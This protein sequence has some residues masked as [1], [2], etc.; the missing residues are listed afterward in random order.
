MNDLAAACPSDHVLFFPAWWI[1]SLGS[2]VL[3]GEYPFKKDIP[4]LTTCPR[5]SW[6][7][8]TIFGCFL[9]EVLS[10]F[11]AQGRSGCIELCPYLLYHR[12]GR[13]TAMFRSRWNEALLGLSELRILRWTG[14]RSLSYRV[15]ESVTWTSSGSRLVLEVAPNSDTLELLSGFVDMYSESNRRL[16]GRPTLL[17]LVKGRQPLTVNRS[18]WL[19]LAGREASCY[20][21]LVTH[22]LWGSS[23]VQAQAYAMGVNQLASSPGLAH[24]DAGKGLAL[25]RRVIRRIYRHGC[26]SPLD[27]L[28]NYFALEEDQSRDGVFVVYANDEDAHA[29]DLQLLR[30]RWLRMQLD[31]LV[32]SRS[33]H[34]PPVDSSV[35]QKANRLIEAFHRSTSP[36][37][38]EAIY[39]QNVLV[40]P[41][42][43]LL[44]EWAL[45]GDTQNLPDT[46]TQN[47]PV[48]ELATLDSRVNDLADNFDS[49]L[50]RLHN[51][52]VDVK[53]AVV[54]HPSL[55]LCYP[56]F[57]SSS[58]SQLDSVSRGQGAPS[59]KPVE[60]VSTIQNDTSKEPSSV[61]SSSQRRGVELALSLLKRSSPPKFERIQA[62]YL[63]SLESSERNILTHIQDRLPADMFRKQLFQ[64]VAN[65]ALSD[66]ETLG[67]LFDPNETNGKFIEQIPP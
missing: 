11:L 39:F 19:D 14:K 64:R 1:D 23:Q 67:E 22:A 7:N 27:P 65:F 40:L 42:V 21:S 4:A 52:R 51:M 13:C 57:G 66:R 18:I 43:S 36:H 3:E 55:T 41:H 60:Q 26:M 53:K 31:S 37:K 50:E 28:R 32:D 15:F 61:S 63:A 33:L 38:Y 35:R 46:L 48:L 2:E 29:R 5:T 24:R 44:F 16:S 30:S 6:A 10:G 49:A 17:P 59:K 58:D 62:R 56:L 45:R 34:F 47:L 9:N 12:F 25:C 20:L 54:R 8:S